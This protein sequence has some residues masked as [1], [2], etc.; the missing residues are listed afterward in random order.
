MLQKQIHTEKNKCSDCTRE[1]KKK[2]E[3]SK[4]DVKEAKH[5]FLVSLSAFLME[6]YGK[7]MRF[8]IYNPRE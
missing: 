8:I 7:R 5:F 1:G 3:H 4:T 2:V 6:L